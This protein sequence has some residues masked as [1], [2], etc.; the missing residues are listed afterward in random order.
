MET[1][2]GSSALAAIAWDLARGYR[3]HMAVMNPVYPITALYWGPVALWFYWQRGGRMS[4]RW[5]REHGTDLDELM[6][7]DRDD[8]S[9]IA[10]GVSDLRRG[11]HDRR[12]R[13]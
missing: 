1:Q 12:H 11:L 3:Q 7:E 10:K 2:T 8:A 5:A 9:A 13:W 6:D 4:S